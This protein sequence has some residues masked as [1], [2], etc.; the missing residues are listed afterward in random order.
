M[1]LALSST[2]PSLSTDT[3]Q[4][5]LA[6]TACAFRVCALTAHCILPPHS[7]DID[8]PWVIVSS[9][10]VLK[11]GGGG[12][13]SIRTWLY[14]PEAASPLSGTC[15]DI[16]SG[17]DWIPNGVVA[18]RV[19]GLGKVVTGKEGNYMDRY[20]LVSITQIHNTLPRAYSS[21]THRFHPCPVKRE[22]NN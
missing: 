13:V 16:A 2:F 3:N 22:Y 8:T 20:W 1:S 19:T 21:D 11:E 5:S 12:G 4:P 9:S 14:L 10:S 7:L 15:V 6:N 18:E 17:G